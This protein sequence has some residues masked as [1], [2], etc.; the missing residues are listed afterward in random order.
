M[1]RNVWLILLAAVLAVLVLWW[2]TSAG[3]LR[4]R[5][6]VD[7]PVADAI[8]PESLRAPG[9]A[10]AAPPDPLPV[11]PDTTPLPPDTL[12]PAPAPRARLVVPVQGIRAS[13]L[14]DTFEDA[15]GR[16]REHDAIDIIA[17]RGTPVLAATDGR[18]V[19]LFDSE[20]GGKTIYQRGRDART[21]YYYAH[22]DRYAAGLRKGDAVRQGQVVGYVGDTGNAVP[23]NYHL[24]F[25]IWIT[26]DTTQYWDG[27]TI[28]PYPLLKGATEAQP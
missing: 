22:L 28:N 1:P 2:S 17:P 14:V 21:I 13:D 27:D 8:P 25:A 9:P 24:H 11:P 26:P 4:V 23:G 15:R 18:V 12:A 5:R 20:R 10:E 3:L 16:G 19:D 7:V 6:A